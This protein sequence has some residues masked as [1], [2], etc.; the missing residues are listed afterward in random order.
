M[1]HAIQTSQLGK[2]I[3]LFFLSHLGQSAHGLAYAI[4]FA[5][6]LMGPF[7]PS[8][9]ARGGG[10][11]MPVV[12][13]M[14]Q[15]LEESALPDAHGTAQ[16]LVLCG[17]HYNLLVSSMFLTATVGNPFIIE[18]AKRAFGIDFGFLDW[19]LGAFV[20]GLMS[21]WALP[22]LFM[23][24]GHVNYQSEP[25]MQRVKIEYREMGSLTS[26]EKRVIVVFLICL[27]LWILGQW[28]NLPETL[29][30]MVGIWLLWMFE[31]LSWKDVIQNSNAW[32]AFFWL[33]VMIMLS[34]QLAMTGIPTEM[35]KVVA[36]W[37]SIF[38]STVAMLALSIVYFMSMY[39]FSSLT[40][41]LLSLA[42]SFFVA[43]KT[44]N[45][46]PFATIAFIGYFSSLCGCLV[47]EFLIIY[48]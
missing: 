25:V 31:I 18:E 27:S 6:L 22:F 5:E 13:S 14:I 3:A 47:N 17:F 37:V 34:K 7:V 20:P 45:C 30:A 9:S 10:I 33:S 39:L 24:T 35:G 2:R 16:F 21:G 15:V 42:P 41:H 32:D 26:K 38:P 23:R 12:S 43:A 48:R 40:G 46:S 19:T 44:L 8:N 1:G 11:I 36:E 4:F 29:A 28:L